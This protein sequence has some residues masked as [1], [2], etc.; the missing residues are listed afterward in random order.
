MSVHACVHVHPCVLWVS[1]TG[2]PAALFQVHKK[3]GWWLCCNLTTQRAKVRPRQANS[4]NGLFKLPRQSVGGGT[5]NKRAGLQ[6][7]SPYP[8]KQLAAL[9]NTLTDPTSPPN[10]HHKHR[11]AASSPHPLLGHFQMIIIIICCQLLWWK[12]PLSVLYMSVCLI[13]LS[14]LSWYV[15]GVAGD[16]LCQKEEWRQ[17]SAKCEDHTCN[18]TGRVSDSMLRH[19]SFRLAKCKLPFLQ[20]NDY[21]GW[22]MIG[23]LFSGVIIS[24][25][26]SQKNQ[27]LCVYQPAFKW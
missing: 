23:S 10:M 11:H 2:H 8:L 20:P 18:W 12:V 1:I 3:S 9:W 24:F 17:H 26:H 27:T 21:T 19:G 5:W 13:S 7:R 16:L 14:V 15:P 25:C 22:V 6:E 4:M